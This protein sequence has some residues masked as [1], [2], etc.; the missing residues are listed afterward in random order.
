MKYVLIPSATADIEVSDE[1]R[2]FPRDWD[3]IAGE[4]LI[5]H[6]ILMDVIPGTGNC[7]V[8]SRF[9]RTGRWCPTCERDMLP[10]MTERDVGLRRQPMQFNP[11]L[12][13]ELFADPNLPMEWMQPTEYSLGTV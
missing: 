12:M 6:D 7:P 3:I 11:V 4:W 1:E 13:Q 8:C 2:I 9:G 5:S 10:V